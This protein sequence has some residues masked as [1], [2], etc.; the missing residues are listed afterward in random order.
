V[1]SVVHGG[2]TP[3]LLLPLA[4]RIIAELLADEATPSYLQGST[5]RAAIAGWARAEA[6]V[7]LLSEHVDRLSVEAALAETTDTVEDERRPAMG[8]VRRVSKSQRYQSAWDSLLRAEK[9]AA[10]LR[11]RLG[12]DPV[13]RG[14]LGRDLREGFDLAAYLAE[15]NVEEAGTSGSQDRPGPGA[16]S[17]GQVVVAAGT[18]E[19]A[20]GELMPA[21]AETCGE[22]GHSASVIVGAEDDIVGDAGSAGDGDGVEQAG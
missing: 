2:E 7:R 13:A 21:E 8:R 11:T 4:E 3:R 18:L 12:L 20:P 19:A 9:H 22:K 10:A 16:D 14:R 15:R 5:Y 17:V 6:A 1:A